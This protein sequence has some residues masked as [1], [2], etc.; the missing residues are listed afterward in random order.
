MI[1]CLRDRLPLFEDLFPYL[2]PHYNQSFRKS[3][4][5]HSK[6]FRAIIK[7]LRVVVSGQPSF[8]VFRILIFFFFPLQLH[9]ALRPEAFMNLYAVVQQRHMGLTAE[10]FLDPA[11]HPALVR[12]GQRTGR[13]AFQ[14]NPDLPSALMKPQLRPAGTIFKLTAAQRFQAA[15]GIGCEA[16]QLI[17]QLYDKET[18]VERQR[19]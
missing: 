5:F 18:A 7:L 11:L 2:H 17:A 16:V 9:A 19:A 10:A 4:P 3:K 1:G 6:F 12:R 13:P 15:A 8:S 14:T